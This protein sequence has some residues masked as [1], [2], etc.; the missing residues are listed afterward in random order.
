MRKL[1][2]ST[3]TLILDIHRVVWVV[4]HVDNHYWILCIGSNIEWII[5]NI[6]FSS[7]E[8]SICIMW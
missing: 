7:Y 8:G 4:E 3:H 2:F 5:I 1:G 6:G